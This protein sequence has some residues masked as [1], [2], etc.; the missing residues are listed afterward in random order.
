M[1]VKSTPEVTFGLTQFC[2][3][4]DGMVRD[5]FKQR[6]QRVQGDH[7]DVGDDLAQVDRV[8]RLE[9][10]RKENLKRQMEIQNDQNVLNFIF[11]PILNL[12]KPG[13]RRE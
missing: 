12:I 4:K 3:T 11:N 1:L 6:L 10:L 13:M 2:S 7:L 5:F 8:V 9:P